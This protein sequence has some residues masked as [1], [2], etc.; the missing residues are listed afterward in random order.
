MSLLHF[1]MIL[2]SDGACIT[3]SSLSNLTAK[4]FIRYRFESTAHNTRTSLFALPLLIVL[5]LLF[6]ARFGEPFFHLSGYT[7]M[8]GALFG[9]VTAIQGYCTIKA[10]ANGPLSLTTLLSSGLAILIPIFVST[11]FWNENPTALQIVGIGLLIV[12]MVLLMNPRL[13]KQITLKWAV[14]TTIESLC[15]GLEGVMQKIHQKSAYHTE[16]SGMLVTA[17]V[18]YTTIMFISTY[19]VH[20]DESRRTPDPIPPVRWAAGKVALVG[21]VIGLLTS[22]VHMFNLY[23]S[24]AVDAAIFFPLANGIPLLGSAVVG[25][26]VFKETLRKRRLVGFIIGFVSLLATGGVL[27]SLVGLF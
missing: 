27:D 8:M 24:G 2:I 10:L 18:V 22:V 20:R 25:V 13:D 26:L 4:R 1:I 12:A 21:L 16:L 14:F 3:N 17:F 15:G 6:P 23:L 7:V 19:V 11:L 9:T 5:P